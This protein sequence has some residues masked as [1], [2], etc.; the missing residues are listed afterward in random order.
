M[1]LKG[2]ESSTDTGYGKEGTKLGGAKEVRGRAKTKIGWK[3]EYSKV[4]TFART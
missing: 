3:H 4:W 2:G 1:K